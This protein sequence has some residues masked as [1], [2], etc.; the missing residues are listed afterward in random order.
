VTDKKAVV[1]WERTG[2]RRPL[3]Q[4]VR[5]SPLAQRDK[6]KALACAVGVYPVEGEPVTVSRI[7]GLG[8]AGVH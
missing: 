3:R 1:F 6:P 2:A 5:L 4:V 7:A 8:L